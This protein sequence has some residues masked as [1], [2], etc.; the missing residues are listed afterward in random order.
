MGRF[1]GSAKGKPKID[2]YDKNRKKGVGGLIT[3]DSLE[4]L[5]L[6]RIMVVIGSIWLI[7]QVK[8]F[9]LPNMCKLVYPVSWYWFLLIG[10]KRPE[11]MPSFKG[12]GMLGSFTSGPI[13]SSP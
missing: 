7:V 2:I 8:R 1:A 5:S 4:Q 10:V 13:V 9:F 11:D 6:L 3:A 12:G